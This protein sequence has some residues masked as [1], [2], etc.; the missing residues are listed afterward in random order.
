MSG[1]QL[2]GFERR[3]TLQPFSKLMLRTRVPTFC[4]PPE[5]TLRV[6]TF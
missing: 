3:I 4:H 2:L 6:F 1:I 5:F